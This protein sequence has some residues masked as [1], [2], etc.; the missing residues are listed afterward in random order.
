V[1]ARVASFEGVNVQ[2]AERTMGEAEALI[3]PIFENLAGF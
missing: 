2:Q 3:R 1:V